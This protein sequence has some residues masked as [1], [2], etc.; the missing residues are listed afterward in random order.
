ME[1]KL[2]SLIQSKS[3]LEL[4]DDEK[5]FVIEKIGSE[6]RYDALRKVN[7]ALVTAQKVDLSPDPSTLR[8]L[9]ERLKQKRQP[10]FSLWAYRMPAVASLLLFVLVGAAGWYVGRENSIKA[11]AFIVKTDTVYLSTP[12][13]TIYINKVVYRYVPKPQ[14]EDTKTIIV[15]NASTGSRGVSMKEKEDLEKLLVSGTD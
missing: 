9:H 7:R 5:T 13:D 12:P 1:E 8:D 3:W 15:K 14:I 6:A 10:A 11:T 4:D 2:E